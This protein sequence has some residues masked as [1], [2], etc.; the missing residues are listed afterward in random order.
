MT[1]TVR[2]RL[3]LALVLPLLS[4]CGDTT[5]APQPVPIPG[6]IRTTA[7]DLKELGAVVVLGLPGAVPGPGAITAEVEGDPSRSKQV[8]ASASG[9][10]RLGLLAHASEALM[11][12][13]EGGA[14]GTR[15]LIPAVPA[16]VPLQMAGPLVGVPPISRIS[17]DQVRIRGQQLG[18]DASRTL[19]VNLGTGEVRVGAVASDG[20]FQIELAAAPG[21]TIEVY[22][23]HSPLEAAWVLTAP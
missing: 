7:T 4:H 23:D 9:S 19:A 21:Q 18:G 15:V 22:A 3:G 14:D 11:L 6:L 20:S 8:R 10:F 1:C 16:I 13:F 5:G 2:L 17:P 12:R